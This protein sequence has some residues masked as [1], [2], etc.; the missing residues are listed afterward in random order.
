MITLANLERI[1]VHGDVWNDIGEEY[2]D[3]CLRLAVFT[4]PVMRTLIVSGRRR[5]AETFSGQQCSSND[6]KRFQK[7][8]TAE[9]AEQHLTHLLPSD[10]WEMLQLLP[11][12]L[13]P[14]PEVAVNERFV[15]I[16]GKGPFCQYVPSKLDKYD[17]NI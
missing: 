4:N 13:Q 7:I 1:K 12:M 9:A 11:L 14:E 15:P 10:V 17:K 6:F 2:L 5:Q 8:Q 3:I 16:C